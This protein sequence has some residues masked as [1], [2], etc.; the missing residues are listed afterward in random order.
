MIGDHLIVARGAGTTV[1]AVKQ[2]WDPEELI[3]C[4]TLVEQD[5]PLVGNKTGATRLGFA[6]L[7]KFVEIEGRFPDYPEEIPPAAVEFVAELVKV[8]PAEFAK[9]SLTNRTAEYHRAQIREALEVRPATVADEQRW[10]EWL[11]TDQCSVE[12]DRGRLEAAVR[13]RC[14]S[15]GI[16]P[17]TDG[18]IERVVNS[19]V[20][21][22]EIAFAAEIHGKLNV[23]TCA[24]L[25][26]LLVTEGTLAEVKADPGPLGLETLLGE[27][28][29]LTTVRKLALPQDLF[30]ETSDRLVAAW[31]SR[32]ARMFPS[33]FAACEPPVRYTLLAALCWVRQAE[34]TDALVGLLVDLVH[35]INARA[36]RR[37]EKELIGDLTSTPGKKRI[38][39]KMVNAVLDKPDEV[40]REA[41]WP[42]VPGGE[43][44]LRN[45]VKELMASNRVIQERVRY[46]LRGSYTHHYRRMLGPVLAALRFQ[47]N[48][49]HYRPVMDAVE[50][51]ARYAKADVDPEA[52]GKGKKAKVAVYSAKDTVPIEG[53]VPKAWQDAVTDSKGRIERIPYELCVLIALREALRRREIWV[54][55]AGRWRDPEEDL[56]DNFADNRDVHYAALR[57]PLDAGEFVAD[58]KRRHT[59]AMDALNTALTKD[60]A[61]GVKIT[62]RRGQPWISVPK[63]EKLPEPKNLAAVKSE[64]ARRWG[65]IDLLDI[66]KN[67]DLFTDFT[68]DFVSVATREALTKDVLR[69]RLLLCLFALGTNMGIRQMVATGEHDEDEG[70]LRRVRASHITRENLRNAIV[71]VVN[72]TFAARDSRWWGKATTTASD[73]KRFGSWDS[74]LM[75]QF[76]ARYG[77]GGIMIYWHVEK[78][79]VCIYSQLKSCSSSEVA[80]MIEG[81]LRHCTDAEIEANYTDTHGASVVGFA[82]TELLGFRLL[83]RLKNIGSIKLYSPTEGPNTWTK[84]SKVIVNRPIDWDKITQQYDQMVKYATALRLGTAEAEQVLRR[85][86]KGG[87]PKSPT[88]LAMEELGRVVRT[89]FACEFLASEDLRREINSGLQ[90]VENWNSANE[91]IFYGKDG[92]LTG[93]DREHAEV[94][95]LA[96][97]LLQSCLVYVNTLLLQKVLDDPAWAK[98]LTPEDRRGLNALFWSHVNPYGRFRLDMDTRLDLDLAA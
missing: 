25:Q 48:N 53:V 90:V 72:A 57:K 12:Q 26:A 40:V 83:P 89:I 47:C 56:P 9:Y 42:V 93:P 65:T 95:M 51:L 50:L 59:A 88:Y 96:L 44:T 79:R 73:S 2:D 64:V 38:F 68:E 77:A 87:G 49:T 35:R 4:W 71:K 1:R 15:E 52:P 54:Q 37:V 74:N 63:L 11:A 13:Q 85:F 23:V 14:R 24:G 70:A 45:L 34:I 36:E 86:T 32:A 28:D 18:Q 41:V 27:I 92:M 30:A 66:L 17:P 21:R 67:S 5:W 60:T 91:A 62:T 31:R 22:H 46:Q 10:V 58:L 43:K 75:T 97:H 76:H 8:D 29:K 80:A 6:L 16:E 98:R 33:D 82:F 19:A 78:E 3:A 20:R 69:R 84:L 55:G 39:L 94:S 61:G 81:L 7:L